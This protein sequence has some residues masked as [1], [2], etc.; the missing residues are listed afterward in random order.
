[1]RIPGRL[2]VMLRPREV[3]VPDALWRDRTL[4]EGAK[5][6]WCML[7][8]MRDTRLPGRCLVVTFGELRKE[9]GLS[10]NSIRLYFA[11]LQAAGWLKVI[12]MSRSK[13]QVE[14]RWPRGPHFLVLPEDILRDRELPHAARWIWGVIRRFGRQFDYLQLKEL[15]GYSHNTL[16]HHVSLLRI[17]GWL[18]GDDGYCARRKQFRLT[19]A[20]PPEARR[21]AELAQFLKAAERA[22]KTDRY[23]WGQFLMEQIVALVT[24]LPVIRNGAA[25]WLVNDETGAWLEYD[26][27]LH[28]R[29]TAFEFHGPQ[30]AGPTERFPDPEVAAAQQR[31]DQLKRERSRQARFRCYEIW[32]QNLSFP[33]ITDCLRRAGVALA[34]VPD[35]KRYVYVLLEYYS[36]RYRMAAQQ[37]SPASRGAA[38]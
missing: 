17:R 36:E 10:H 22:E 21:Q 20:N 12:R 7:R 14:I 8:L 1:M 23:S 37:G 6:F 32:A 31:R 33:V 18:E 28:G 34:P 15:T 2:R 5:Y 19:A 3:L 24:Q 30:H 27:L 13:L 25:S 11:E 35:E 29:K 16:T 38:V 9:T 26:V 4:R